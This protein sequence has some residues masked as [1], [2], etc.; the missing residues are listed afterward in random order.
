MYAEQVLLVLELSHVLFVHR[1]A[2]QHT[3]SEESAADRP[4]K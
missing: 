3:S 2:Q 1:S 4:A